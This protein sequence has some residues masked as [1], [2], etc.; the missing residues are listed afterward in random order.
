M[1]RRKTLLF[2]VALVLLFGSAATAMEMPSPSSSPAL[3]ITG[4]VKR[5]LN[6]TVKDLARFQSVEVQLNEVS[7]DGNFH[8]VFLHQAVPLRTLLDMAEIK[9]QA[10]P[11]E[12][13]I[14][15]AI[16]VT[17]HSG[18]QVVLSWGKSIT[19]MPPNMP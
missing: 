5:P 15:L 13:E 10:Q 1:L 16:R 18:R 8:G 11:F 3:T 9:K 14:D 4:E 7:R 2:G 19:A 17:D 12:K 6:L